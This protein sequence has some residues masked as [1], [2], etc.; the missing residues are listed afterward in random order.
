[1]RRLVAIAVLSGAVTAGAPFAQGPTP[2]TLI[3]VN[4]RVHTL[5]AANTTAEAVAIAGERIVATGR[6]ADLRRTAGADARV[7][8]LGGR[9]VVPGLMDNHLHGAGGGPGVDLSRARSLDDVARALRGR[10]SAAAPGEVIVSNSDWHEGQLRE[11]RLP[12]RDDL[13]RVAPDHP[14]VLVRGGHEYVLNSAALRRWRI[15]ERTSV[16]DGGRITRYS[17][18]RLNGELVDTARGL[19]ALPPPAPRSRE[20][21]IADRAAEYARLHAAGLTTVRHPGVSVDDYRLLE[22][23]QRRG[24]LTMRVNAL[25]RP[26]GDGAAVLAALDGSGVRPDHGDAWLRVGGVKLAVD[27]GFEGGLM[28]DPYAAPWDEGGT[29]RGLQL[30][31][32]T[33]FEQTVLAL[34]DRGWRVATHAVGDA[35]IDLVLDAYERA[36][37]RQPITGRR[38]SIEHAF[39]GRPDHLPRIRA[40]GLALSVQNH[41]YLA[42]PSLVQYWG[43]ARAAL[44]TPVRL[45]L[46]AGL[47]VSSGTDAPVVP[48]PP[49]WT[50]YHF[51]TRDTIA[52]G[53]VGA[54]QRVT[55]L[56][57]LRMATTGNAWLTMEERDKGS[58]EAGKL[59]DLVVLSDD[60]LTCP[61]PRLRDADVTMTI[62]GGRIVHDAARR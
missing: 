32:R 6:S 44:T 37:A 12:L 59:A 30:V 61:E 18:G 22:E 11:R 39:I 21:R 47:P 14:V 45:Y 48:Y 42:A 23:M 40:L 35:G 51:A 17:D 16:P 58:I 46:D 57:A 38:W 10:V 4:A 19:V 13:D 60:P 20:Q 33:E 26:G 31:P 29:F 24:V 52:G 55:R 34:H 7:V 53:V 41:L 49:L 62:V 54:D 15:D 27:G 2:P 50:L 9:T 25:L 43:A 36:H 5:D 56:E 1:M 8:D 28:R 3:L